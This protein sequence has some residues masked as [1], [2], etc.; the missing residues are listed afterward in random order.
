MGSIIDVARREIIPP[1]GVHS[2][3]SAGADA[4][5][6]SSEEVI[7]YVREDIN[8]LAPLDFEVF[9][10]GDP[11]TIM[12]DGRLREFEYISG[13]PVPGNPRQNYEKRDEDGF[14]FPIGRN[15]R[16]TSY[17]RD[18]TL[19]DSGSGRR[20][21]YRDAFNMV[22]REDAPN[23]A[24]E[25]SIGF[26]DYPFNL[27]ILAAGIAKT[28]TVVTPRMSPGGRLYQSDFTENDLA[29]K[30]AGLRVPRG[31]FLFSPRGG[32]TRAYP[33][34]SGRVA[35]RARAFAG[36]FRAGAVYF[37]AGR[38]DRDICSRRRSAR[39]GCFS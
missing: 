20:V 25:P 27:R 12:I 23:T 7:G 9:F 16:V 28:W 21:V 32:Q 8:L 24:G 35:R 1:F 2:L 30:L 33:R 38:L 31:A 17:I 39:G 5:W 22:Y 10:I 13:N 29:I 6:V 18:N 11:G 26:R 15:A 14:D 3:E 36:R 4:A 19:G 34:R 37:R